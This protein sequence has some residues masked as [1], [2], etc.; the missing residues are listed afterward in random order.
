MDRTTTSAGDQRRAIRATFLVSGIGAIIAS[1]VVGLATARLL[2]GLLTASL[3]VLVAVF[4]VGLT[5]RQS[6]SGDTTAD[7][8]W[9]VHRGK[10]IAGLVGTIAALGALLALVMDNATIT[11]A[12]VPPLG[13][14]LLGYVGLAISAALAKRSRSKVNK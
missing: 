10:R 13:I 9:D 5:A 7:I 11:A 3:G 2:A 6:R 4:A 1:V 14:A 12:F 8:L